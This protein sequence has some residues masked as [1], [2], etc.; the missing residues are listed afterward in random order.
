MIVLDHPDPAVSAQIPKAAL[1]RF[2]T[3]A[4]RAARLEGELSIL[5]ADDKQ[6]KQLNKQFRGKNKP[7]DVLSF[8]AP[9]DM[10]E[11]AGDLALSIDTAAKQ[12]AEFNHSLDEELRI[13]LLHGI[14]HLSGYDHEA[15]SGEMAA[16]EEELRTEL[17]LST[18]L[19]HRAQSPK[20]KSAKKSAAP[21][22]AN[23]STRSTT[24]P[25]RATMAEKVGR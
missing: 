7:T 5:L 20:K 15:D 25:K 13:L 23:R 21:R 19:I 17:G 11:L 18:N 9:E 2:V 4:K 10:R 24:R 12:A 14:L 3:R 16:R 1:A 22:E 6:L 8:P